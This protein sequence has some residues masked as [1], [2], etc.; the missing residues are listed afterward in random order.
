VR[1]V[2]E[3]GTEEC[4]HDHHAF[5]ADV[6]DAGA[7]GPQPTKAGQ[8]D[9]DGQG[10]RRAHRAAGGDVVG[11]GDGAHEGQQGQADERDEQVPRA[12]QPT[13]RL[14]PIGTHDVDG[15]RRGRI[16]DVHASAPS[17]AEGAL[18]AARARPTVRC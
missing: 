15:A 17:V 11:V 8:S 10:Y 12:A 14:Y 3:V 5:E 13:G 1:E 18:G 9:G 2:G 7:L 16:L 4:T 6:H